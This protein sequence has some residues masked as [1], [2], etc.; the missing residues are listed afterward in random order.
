MLADNA[1]ESVA[2]RDRVVVLASLTALTVLAWVYLFRDAARMAAMAPDM[3]MPWTSER[4]VMTLLMW[5]IMMVGMMLPSAAPM[6]VFYAQ[7]VRKNAERGLVL[8]SVWIFTVAYLAVWTG[9]S[10]MATLLQLLL[11]QLAGMSPM[12]MKTHG[13]V[14]GL[15]LIIAGV[16]QW[17]PWKKVCLKYCRT[18]LQF[19]TTRWRK[20]ALG[21]LRMGLEHGA[22]CVGCCWV[23]MLLLFVGGVMNLLWVAVIAGFVLLEKILP[24]GWFTTRIAGFGLMA[25]GLWQL[26]LPGTASY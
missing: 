18:P 23:L 12:S 22:F 20:G 17:L 16:Y 11:E 4:F 21:A 24:A 13:M 6:I 9:F 1:I 19:I 26:L 25:V 14:S 5:S 2:R 7:S 15:L 10:V 3:P 8:P